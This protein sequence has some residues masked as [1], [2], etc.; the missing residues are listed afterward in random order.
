MPTVLTCGNSA[1]DLVTLRYNQT[2]S[3]GP[4]WI[5]PQ[6][7]GGVATLKIN[8]D[9][10]GLTVI[11]GSSAGTKIIIANA[12]SSSTATI[13]NFNGTIYS[14]TTLFVDGTAVQVGTISQLAGTLILN[15]TIN[16][17][18]NATWSD[19]QPIFLTFTT[20]LGT[21]KVLRIG[22]FYGQDPCLPPSDPITNLNTAFRS[23]VCQ[24]NFCAGNPAGIY[25]SGKQ[26]GYFDGDSNL[27]ITDLNYQDVVG[28]LS[29][30]TGNASACNCQNAYLLEILFPRGLPLTTSVFYQNGSEIVPLNNTIAVCTYT[31]DFTGTSVAGSNAITVSQLTIN[32]VNVFSGLLPVSSGVA[33][34]NLAN[35]VAGLA[36]ALTTT[37]QVGTFTAVGTTLVLKSPFLFGSMSGKDGAAT[38]A[39]F[40]YT[41]SRTGC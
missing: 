25:V 17:A 30:F 13:S 9:L 15:C 10:Q 12:L 18:V 1:P 28:Y 11:P 26:I 8:F 7:P 20:N 5:I 27:V 22:T 38:P 29:V 23:Y 3:K 36:T 21:Q 35:Q 19:A 34:N 33:T 31:W 6:L 37:L 16:T 40:T 32:G 2:F 39:A 41:S 4:V 24:F 14:S